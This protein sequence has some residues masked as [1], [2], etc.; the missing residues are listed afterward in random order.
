[1][2]AAMREAI[3]IPDATLEP[4]A[5][6]RALLA[7]LGDRDAMEVDAETPHAIRRLCGG[8]TDAAW[9][10]P[11]APGEWNAQQIVG[12]LLDV[13]IVYGFRWR[14]VL[15]EDEPAYPRYNEKAWSRS[16]PPPGPAAPRQLRG[17]SR[18]QRRAG[19]QPASRGLAPLRRSRKT[20]P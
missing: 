3:E 16:W 1:M 17:A 19:V 12:H 18:G 4:D 20:G 15:T 5:Y 2:E 14:L 6:V 11:L 9:S 7:T 8:L 13:D 10:V